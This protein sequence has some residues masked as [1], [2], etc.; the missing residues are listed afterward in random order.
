MNI[1]PRIVATIWKKEISETLRDRRTLF[2]TIGVPV[3]IYPLLMMGMSRLAESESEATLARRSTI[4]VWGQV[5]AALEQ[6]LTSRSRLQLRRNLGLP[7]T[8]QTQLASGDVPPP[9]T[10]AVERRG[11]KP[12]DPDV[13]VPREE[14]P[15]AF[16]DAARQV[17]DDRQAD[18]VLMVWGHGEATSLYFDSVREESA[19]AY[20]RLRRALDA[21]TDSVTRRP[22]EIAT[23]DIAPASRQAGRVIGTILPFMLLTLCIMGGLYTAIDLAAGEKERG[24]MQTLMCAPVLPGEIITGKFLAVWVISLASALANIASLATTLTRTLPLDGAAIPLSSYLLAGLILLPVTMLTSAL[25]LA[26]AVFAKDY[27]E[28]Q[29]FLTPV[30]MALVLPGAVTMLPTI[31]LNAWTTLV[32]IINIALLVKALLIGDARPEFVF[33][34]LASSAMYAALALTLA[35]RVFQREQVLL[36]GRESMRELF[37]LER[38]AARTP[39][40]GLALTVFSVALVASFYGSLLLEKRGFVTSLLIM[41]YGFFLLPVVAAALLL[42][43]NLRETFS[44]R[45]PRAVPL[46]AAAVLG[47]AAWTFA[48]GILLRIAP[49]PESLVRALERLVRLTD[50]GA[51][52][53]VIWLVVAVTP[54]ICEEALFRGFILSGLRRLGPVAAIGISSLLFGIAHASIYRLLPT[55]FLGV[56]FGLIVWRT[57]S[58]LSSIVAH[59]LNNGLLATMTEVPEMAKLFG[60]Q[61]GSDALPWPATLYGTFMM[62]A[63]LFVLIS[64]SEGGMFLVRNRTA[65]GSPTAETPSASR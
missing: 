6:S 25:F 19:V 22:F 9:A 12:R 63:A 59:T 39:S 1:R 64:L 38:G 21:F 14:V 3:L 61:P 28:G 16:M 53:W 24:T 29:S 46:V 65:P 52:L 17:I 42:R 26:L 40:P 47:L 2:L 32:P 55:F 11:D 10:R 48:S 35:V 7:E 15:N 33:L 62:L 20:G 45:L 43:M 54:A 8:L 56:I 58:L 34:T 49:P 31:E 57:G 50:E 23:S 13:A 27:K 41:Q 5:P 37:G 51:P 60:V 36:G 4:A 30:Y 44:L 18:A